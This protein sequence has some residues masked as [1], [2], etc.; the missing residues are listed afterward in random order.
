MKRL[1]QLIYFARHG[2]RAIIRTTHEVCA[3]E[4]DFETREEENIFFQIEQSERVFKN[5]S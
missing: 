1:R 3:S 4:T 5:N 2:N